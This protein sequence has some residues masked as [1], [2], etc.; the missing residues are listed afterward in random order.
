VLFTSCPGGG[1]QVGGWPS[2]SSALLA[3]GF[4]EPTHIAHAGDG[5][6]R[7]FVAER[8]GLIRIVRSGQALPRPFLDIRGRVKTSG[9]EQGLLCVAFPPGYREKGYFYVN[10]TEAKKGTTVVALYRVTSDPDL[11]DPASEEVLLTVEQPFANHNG[12]QMAFGPDGYFYIGMGDGGAGGDPFNNAQRLDTLLGKLLRVDTE[13]GKQGRYSIPDGNPFAK[14]PESRG[15]VWAYGLRNPWRFSFDRKTGDL[16]I[17]DV[18]QNRYEEIDFQPASSGGGENYGWRIME[19]AHC[20]LSLRDCGREGLAAPAAEYGH[21]GGNCSVTGGFVYRGKAQPALDGI[22]FYGDF[23]SGRVWGLRKKGAAWE[24]SML[25]DTGYAISTFGE[26]EAGEVY[27]ADYS[28]GDIYA[29]T[30]ARDR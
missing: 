1:G 24:T 9:S 15:E 22:Y 8:G 16:Y 2:I 20:F 21:S 12:G 29:L 23:C 5:S 3:R 27:L 26:D 14:R 10:Y 30:V 28:A 18:G 25:L 4:S 11:A 13:S 17:A 19:G 6:G 7:I